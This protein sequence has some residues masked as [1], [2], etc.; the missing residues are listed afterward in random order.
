MW[1]IVEYFAQALMLS[2]AQQNTMRA[3]EIA[4]QVALMLAMH[5]KRK[6]RRGRPQQVFPGLV[7][8]IP[9]PGHPSFPSGHALESHMIALA[10]ARVVPNEGGLHTALLAMADRIGKNRE[11]AGVHF[12]SDTLA[13]KIIAHKLFGYLEGCALFKTVVEAAK[14]EHQSPPL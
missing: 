10:L 11:I 2:P 6:F 13:G 1:A 7:P 3:M 9:P 14:K 12:A 5:F 4:D 8:L